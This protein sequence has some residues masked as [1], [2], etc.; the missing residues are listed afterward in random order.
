MK[1]EKTRYFFVSTMGKN[2]NRS[3]SFHSFTI[4]TDEGYPSY[5]KCIKL[6][7]EKYPNV[8]DMILLSISEL[9]EEDFNI[10]ISE[11]EL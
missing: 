3:Q 5:D 10:F 4:S 2:P 9:S 11:S 7:E 1:T 6:S 8:N